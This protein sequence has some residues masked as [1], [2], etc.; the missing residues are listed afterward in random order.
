MHTLDQQAGNRKM[1]YWLN[2]LLAIDQLG[3][4]IAA[5]NPDNTISARVGYF[6][7]ADHPS[8]I[9]AY[10]KTLERIIDFTFHPIQGAGHCRNAWLA[11]ADET[12]TQ[13]TYIARIILG[14][15]VALGCAAISVF[16]RL[17]VLI[18]PRL[19]YKSGI[20]DYA[21]WRQSRQFDARRRISRMEP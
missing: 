20:L 19:H 8:R 15:F 18:S 6:A 9:K 17:A 2:V 3:N 13:G 12:D 5:G 10:W 1:P 11:E 14:I 7:S 21:A 4:A 16:I